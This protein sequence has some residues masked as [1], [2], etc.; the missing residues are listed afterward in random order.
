MSTWKK[1]LVSGDETNN[2]IGSSNLTI[3]NSV[4]R[5]LNFGNTLTNYAIKNSSG[6][7]IFY[8]QHS[9]MRL[10][11]DASNS[12][13]TDTLNL[14]TKTS[15]LV[16]NS[17]IATFSKTNK[18]TIESDS[19]S[20]SAAPVLDLYRNDGSQ[21]VAGDLIG[22]VNFNGDDLVNNKTTYAQVVGEIVDSTNGIEDGK[23]SIKVRDNNSLNDAFVV[24]GNELD[25]AM[26][27]SGDSL[28]LESTEEGGTASPILEFKRPKST[29]APSDGDDIGMLKFTATNSSVDGD[30]NYTE[31]EYARVE[32]EAADI[33][34]NVEDANMRF[35][36]IEA[37][38]VQ[39]ALAITPRA[40]LSNGVTAK[41]RELRAIDLFGR[42]LED[43]TNR[44][45]H[46]FMFGSNREVSDTVGG[47]PTIRILRTV[48]GI[49]MGDYDDNPTTLD[50]NGDNVNGIIMP[51]NGFIRAGSLSY[52]KSG[53]STA[54][55]KLKVRTYQHNNM[56][57]ERDFEL[58]SIS[59][60]SSNKDFP[61][62]HGYEGIDSQQVSSSGTDN[63]FQ[64]GAKVVVYL[65]VYSESGDYSLD[66]IIA[67]VTIYSEDFG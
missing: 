26:R 7:A 45:M 13:G 60:Q 15:K 30:G 43:A 40:G 6:V 51:F 54:T 35:K 33:T 31:H 65:E 5:R 29:H 16:M 1:V 9:E 22:S 32:V 21:G 18:L 56:S 61:R 25:V 36:I 48:N 12:S 58:V 27:L 28:S 23:L 49:E 39:N 46:T 34:A 62:G 37:G 20:S 4:A 17:N 55:V 66:D 57:D 3:P 47:N 42:N 63:I 14:F 10:G 59:G 67:S 2:N 64:A 52:R 11:S 41:Q 53:G 38:T 19:N 24:E 8:L 44:F 50:N